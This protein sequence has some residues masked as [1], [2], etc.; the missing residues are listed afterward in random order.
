M[1]QPALYGKGTDTI[2]HVD[3]ETIKV[4]K[5]NGR[6]QWEI[7]ELYNGMTRKVGN[8]E[9]ILIIDLAREM[10]RNSRYY[11]NYI[12]YSNEGIEKVANI[13]YS[14]SYPFLLKKYARE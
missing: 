10:P 12:H 11:F 8:E 9:D 2:T 4:G 3:L 5:I 13:I 7:L 14:H 6:L 1:T